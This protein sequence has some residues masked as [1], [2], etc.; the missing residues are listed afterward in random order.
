MEIVTL[1]DVSVEFN[2]SLILEDV[3]L[4]VNENDFLGIIGPNGGGK[5]TLLKVIL[6]LVKPFKGDV[7]VLD[8]IPAQARGRVGYVPQVSLFDR[9][10]PMTVFDA[11][12]MGR[13][14][15]TGLASYYSSLDRDMAAESLERVGMLDQG[16]RQLGK[17]SEGQKQ[18]VFIARALASDPKLLLLDE[19]TSSV[20]AAMET[21][22]Y[23]VLE[24][25]RS[26]MAIVL[27][28]HDI[29]VISSHIDKIACLN[30]KLYYHDSKEIRKEDLE[31]VYQCPVEMIAHGV[32]HRVMK[33]HQEGHGSRV[34]GQEEETA[35][36]EPR[37]TSD[38][39]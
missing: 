15:K 4:V 8:G 10:F 36:H 28:S 17:L 18:R 27:V 6:G 13:I 34:K 33:E 32:P 2:G 3:S 24:K 7:M 39:K 30:R 31:A 11:V 25:L 35:D 38:E 29:G 5:T 12:L 37:T 16:D 1:S 23:G 26:R 14:G 9:S 20:D 19:P 22:F 21:E